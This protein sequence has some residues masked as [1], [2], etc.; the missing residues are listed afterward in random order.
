MLTCTIT[1]GPY[2]HLGKRLGLRTLYSGNTVAA[3]YG[4]RHASKSYAGRLP[5]AVAK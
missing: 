4:N 1:F 5:L 2:G 3:P